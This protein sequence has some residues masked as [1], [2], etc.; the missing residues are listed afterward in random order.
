MASEKRIK[1]DDGSLERFVMERVHR[2]ALKGAPYN[3]RI[4]S[5]EAKIKLRDNLKRVGLLQP[6]T[7]NRLTGNIVSGH[8]RVSMMDVLMGSDDYHL[9][10]AVV[11]LDEKTEKEQNIFFNNPEGMGDWDFDKLGEMFKGGAL[12]IAYTGFNAGDVK[13]LFGSDVLSLADLNELSDQV[14]AAHKIAADSA[15]A[16][17]VEQDVNFYLVFRDDA[18]AVEFARW[19]QISDH[20]FLN[21]K[22]V[23]AA[24]NAKITAG[25]N[26]P[27]HLLQ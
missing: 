16:M 10:V 27:P 22:E 18:L 1:P 13:D 23:L 26:V 7:W 20:R 8:Q 19:L 9:N 15:C 14:G 4:I 17:D 21:A 2:S 25:E 3:P 11:E 5:D 12:D 24:V 6:I